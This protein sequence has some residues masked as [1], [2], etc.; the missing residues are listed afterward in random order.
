[1][2]DSRR[3]AIIAGAVALVIVIIGYVMWTRSAAP[4]PTI[5]PGQSLQNPFGNQGPKLNKRAQESQPAGQ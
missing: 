4:A 5:G 1:M 2:D 3:N